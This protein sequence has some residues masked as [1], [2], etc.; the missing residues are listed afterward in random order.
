MSG[1]AQGDVVRLTAH[2]LQRVGAFALAT[3]AGKR[4]PGELS[5]DDLGAA[6]EVMRADLEPTVTLA[7]ATAPGGFW[8]GASYMFWPNSAMNPTNRKKL[9]VAERRERLREWRCAPEADHGIDVPCALCGAGALGFFGKVD[10][11]LG[12][13][14]QY[15]NTTARGHEGLALCWGC[16]ASFH[17][18]PYGC[19]VT[20]G[21][22]TALHSWDEAFLQRTVRRQARLMRAKPQVAAGAFGSGR[23]YARQVAGL[24]RLRSY[25]ERLTAGVELVVF[26]NSNKEQTLDTYGL[27]QDLAEW[28]RRVFH[29]QDPGW[30]F[31]VR[32]HHKEK[33]PG[34]SWLA[35]CLF[36]NPPGVVGTSAAYLRNLVINTGVLPGEVPALGALCSSYMSGVLGM[37]EN[38]AKEIRKLAE[39]IADTAN[40]DKAEVKQFVFAT[41]APRELKRWLRRQAVDRTL[42]TSITDPFVTDRQWELLFDSG[43]DSYAL[44]ELLLIRTLMEVQNR[45][46]DWR[47]DDPA[48]RGELD[49]EFDSEPAETD[50]LAE[51]V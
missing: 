38:N 21:R 12:A 6:V 15:L 11:P 29:Q 34:L 40:R 46:P 16:L 36:A 20:G 17:A 51:A 13:S 19:A 47:T 9:S 8:L 24:A 49:D 33:V 43:T 50:D 44:R 31:L 2:P 30:R 1:G 45:A 5:L 28:L 41:R 32:A 26:T 23:P 48:L 27:E 4:H 7:D 25:D 3:L 10:V 42:T 35:R 18:L 39:T 22:A 37:D 14:V